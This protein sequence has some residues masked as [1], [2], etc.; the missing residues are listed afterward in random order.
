MSKLLLITCQWGE[1]ETP[2]PRPVS[3]AVLQPDAIFWQAIA[4]G[5]HWE[6]W[7]RLYVSEFAWSTG[8]LDPALRATAD[9]DIAG[10]II[11][12]PDLRWLYL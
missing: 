5:D 7:T 4:P 3:T 11:A 9:W 1:Q 10:V 6:S 2:D 8:V 12:P